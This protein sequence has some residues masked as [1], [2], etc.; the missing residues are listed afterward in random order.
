LA[1]RN[2]VIHGMNDAF[3]M[4]GCI[5]VGLALL[6]WFAN[7]TKQPAERTVEQEQRREEQEI[8]VEE[9]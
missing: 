4:A 3:W 7:P 5:F 2:S 6:V 8:L 1:G 9:P